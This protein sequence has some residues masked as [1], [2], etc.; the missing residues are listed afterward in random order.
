MGS[1]I[2]I[3]AMR[4][5]N[6]LKELEDPGSTRD[7]RLTTKGTNYHEDSSGERAAD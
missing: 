7:E 2:V 1:V 4:D 6:H 5:L 3:M